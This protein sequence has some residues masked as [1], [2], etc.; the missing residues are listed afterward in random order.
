MSEWSPLP[1]VMMKYVRVHIHRMLIESA[2]DAWISTIAIVLH[3]EKPAVVEGV[4]R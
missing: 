1:D 4:R 3:A 2:L